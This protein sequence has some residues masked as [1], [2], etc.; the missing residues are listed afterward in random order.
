MR[1]SVKCAGANTL[2][3]QTSQQLT[4][5]KING[6]GA[7]AVAA[8]AAIATNDEDAMPDAVVDYYYYFTSDLK[9]EKQ[10]KKSQRMRRMH[11]HNR[12]Y[13]HTHTHELARFLSR[14][15]LMLR[16]NRF[17]N[18]FHRGKV[19]N[20]QRRRLVFVFFRRCRSVRRGPN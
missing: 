17:E 10:K 7:A 14:T 13:V 20:R 18:I 2:N 11:A 1:F 3:V 19:I 8:A 6:D 4:Y 9:Y 15:P 16:Q 12:N 5:P